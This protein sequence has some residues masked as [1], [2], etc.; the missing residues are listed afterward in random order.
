MSRN[1]HC[2]LI[3]GLALLTV[4]VL[5]L[6]PVLAVEFTADLVLVQPGDTLTAKLYVKGMIYRV[7]NL[8]GE[9]QFLAIENRTTDTT[10]ALNPETKEYKALD[11][12]AGAFANPLKGLALT[13]KQM[14][15]TPAG[16]E[17][18]NGY[19]CTKT[20]YSYPGDT[21]VILEVWNSAKLDFIVKSVMH[22]GAEYGDGL[23]EL[24]NITQGGVDET[25]LQIPADYTRLKTPEEIEAALSSIS[26]KA[27][28]EAPLAR[29]IS[30]GGE[31]RIAVTPGNSYRAKVE[32]RCKEGS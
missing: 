13:I 23:T 1:R 9:E 26:G 5:G 12:A 11:G 8:D 25:L 21:T 10:L 27:T 16:T 4:F 19:D 29:R 31:L 18:V 30:V 24:Q 32:N 2:Q 22:F 6:T 15:G 14:E 17:T 3:I 20:L 28:G 7:E